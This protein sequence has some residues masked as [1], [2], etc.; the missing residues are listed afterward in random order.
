MSPM[1][2][3]Q[4]RRS[5]ENMEREHNP[6]LARYVGDTETVWM[7]SEA[8]RWHTRR[9]ALNWIAARSYPGIIVQVPA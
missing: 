4:T 6:R 2:V 3:I 8:K 1:Y 5:A 7:L 9:A